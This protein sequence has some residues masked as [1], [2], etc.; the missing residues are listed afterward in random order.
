M[1][2]LTATLLVGRQRRDPEK[3]HA[4]VM[5]QQKNAIELWTFA[6]QRW[7]K[8]DVRDVLNTILKFS[9]NFFETNPSTDN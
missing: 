9:E 1:P 6:L 8:T 7:P 2:S 5:V 4:S 3:L